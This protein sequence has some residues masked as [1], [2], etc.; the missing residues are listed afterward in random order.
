MFLLPIKFKSSLK[1]HVL[2]NTN[3]LDHSSFAAAA[4]VP[5][6]HYS[7]RFWKLGKKS[8]KFVDWRTKSFQNSFNFQLQSCKTYTSPFLFPTYF[9]NEKKH[10]FIF[11][12]SWLYLELEHPESLMGQWIAM[13]F[14]KFAKS[15]KKRDARLQILKQNT[16]SILQKPNSPLNKHYESVNDLHQGQ[17][18]M[19][20]IVL[21]YFYK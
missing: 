16:C 4:A 3:H 20:P 11:W 17:H 9:E 12:H 2:S 1:T 14:T 13:T 19:F 15:G 5:F 6:D 10:Q 8:G 18:G 7:P 21:N